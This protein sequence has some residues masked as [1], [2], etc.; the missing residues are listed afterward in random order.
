MIN[1]SLLH[2]AGVCIIFGLSVFKL[3]RLPGK[4]FCLDTVGLDKI[5]IYTKRLKFFSLPSGPSFVCTCKVTN[6][7]TAITLL[8]T[9]F[10]PS[11]CLSVPLCSFIISYSITEYK[12]GTLK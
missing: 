6:N 4:F 10:V 2:W 3:G 11:V 1:I 9:L 5:S 7:F 12:M 8:I